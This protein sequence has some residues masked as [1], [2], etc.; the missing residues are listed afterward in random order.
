MD[1]DFDDSLRTGHIG[2]DREHEELF[3]RIKKLV[4]ALKQRNEE[5]EVRVLIKFLEHH[6]KTHIKAEE[7]IMKEIDYPNIEKHMEDH[8]KIVNIVD[9][10]GTNYIHL[11]KRDE[12]IMLLE[13]G[14]C[15]EIINHTKAHDFA[16]INFIENKTA[17]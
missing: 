1:F 4:N 3:T 8:K 2:I 9:Y 16:L 14:L 7:Q 6:S 11:E 5:K 13:K 12:Y 17:V 10:I 15:E